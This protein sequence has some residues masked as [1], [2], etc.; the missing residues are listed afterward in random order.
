MSYIAT[1]LYPAM[2]RI[3]LL[4]C[5][6]VFTSK[7]LR[8]SFDALSREMPIS[9]NLLSLPELDHGRSNLTLTAMYS[10]FAFRFRPSWPEQWIRRRGALHDAKRRPLT[11]SAATCYKQTFTPQHSGLA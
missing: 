6:Q 7:K 1:R 4:T 9:L 2:Q 5:E 8:S 10:V 11:P 3:I